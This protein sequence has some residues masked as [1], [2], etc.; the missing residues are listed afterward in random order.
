MSAIDATR[1]TFVMKICMTG[2]LEWTRSHEIENDLNY[3]KRSWL[4][5]D[6]LILARESA[7]KRNDR[8]IGRMISA[9]QGFGYIATKLVLVVHC[10][11]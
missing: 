9:V 7:T 2:M 8:K 10:S 1:T 11:R 5:P 4:I 6:Y 3:N